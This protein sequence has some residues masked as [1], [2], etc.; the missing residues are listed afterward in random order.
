VCHIQDDMQAIYPSLEKADAIILGS[1]VYFCNV[2]SQ[3]KAIMD[4]THSLFVNK[5]LKG[6][7]AAPVL[8][9]RRV[10]GAETRNL[11]YGFFIAHGMIPVRGA[12]GYGRDKGDV[13]KGVGA[14][15]GL[16][17]LDEARATGKE[18]VQMASR[19]CM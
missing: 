4:R 18:V 17:A 19:A 12:I 11:L 10:G 14:G 8:A 1:P 2:S 16:S 13:T 5:R 6:K 9:V 3:A 7:I 15:P